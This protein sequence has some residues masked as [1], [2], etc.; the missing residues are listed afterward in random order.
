MQL[1]KVKDLSDSID[2]TVEFMNKVKLTPIVIYDKIYKYKAFSDA[3]KESL[4]IY[5]INNNNLR[6]MLLKLSNKIKLNNIVL[7][8]ISD[9]FNESY[10]YYEKYQH[11]NMLISFFIALKIKSELNKKEFEKL[12]IEYMECCDNIEKFYINLKFLIQKEYLCDIFNE[13]INNILNKKNNEENRHNTI[14][15]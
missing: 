1:D 3:V 12:A 10:E 14:L 6:D 5:L 4:E 7:Y 11:L 15:K 9:K 2:N 13:E 8:K